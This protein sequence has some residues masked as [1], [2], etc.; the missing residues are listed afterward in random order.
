MCLVG[1]DRETALERKVTWA[2]L[3][4]QVARRRDHY[5]DVFWW[6][7][8]RGWW[9][10]A[11]QKRAQARVHVGKG[12][13]APTA[14][15]LRCG[16]PSRGAS[17]TRKC[18]ASLGFFPACDAIFAA[19]TASSAIVATRTATRHS[20]SH[21][22][23]MQV[24]SSPAAP[25]TLGA[26]NAASALVFRQGQDAFRLRRLLQEPEALPAAPRL[27]LA[28]S[29]PT[30]K[31]PLVL[32][33]EPDL[34]VLPSPDTRPRGLSCCRLFLVCIETRKEALKITVFR[35]LWPTESGRGPMDSM[36]T[37]N[38]KVPRIW[39]FWRCIGLR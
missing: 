23:G 14:S 9:Y 3:F 4:L 20:T 31:L 38:H 10:R 26:P 7:R 8:M 13:R 37:K 33:W 39:F 19:A 24:V 17:T 34:P 25:T 12:S 27:I 35:C 21:S 32:V 11:L 30:C 15:S 18:C 22:R 29:H 1:L 28:L 2:A 16:A 6:R 5:A 36:A